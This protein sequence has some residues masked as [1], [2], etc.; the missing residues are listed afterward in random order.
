VSELERSQY[1]VRKSVEWTIA[2]NPGFDVDQVSACHGR[3]VGSVKLAVTQLKIMGQ[4]RQRSM[5][6]Y[7]LAAKES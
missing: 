4:L 3:E 1:K 6:G 2:L 7:E 5:G